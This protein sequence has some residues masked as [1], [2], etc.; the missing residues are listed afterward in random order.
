MKSIMVILLTASLTG[1]IHN[2]YAFPPYGYGYNDY[3]AYP[4]GY[5]RGPVR[6]QAIRIERDR[7]EHGYLVNVHLDENTQP[8][9]IQVSVRGRHLLIESK[10]SL[11]REERD[12]GHYSYSRSSSSF[13]RRFLIPSDADAAN[14]QRSDQQGLISITLPYLR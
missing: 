9:A 14:M 4:P 10:R 13:R 11:Q 6:H 8:E 12:E 1:F 3:Q 7:D 5:G 2:S